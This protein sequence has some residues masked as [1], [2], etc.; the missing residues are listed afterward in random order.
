MTKQ[1]K[2]IGKS[3]W[4]SKTDKSGQRI[5]ICQN[6]EPGGK[7][8]KKNLCNEWV[9]VSAKATAVLCYR[10]VNQHVE[11][12]VE[13]G[14]SIKSDRPKGWKFMRLFVAIDGTVFHKGVEQTDLKGTLPITVITPKV[15]KVKMS[16]QEKQD[17]IVALGKEIKHLKSEL[18]VETRKGKRSELSRN[19]TKA[20]RQLNKLM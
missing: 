7:W 20:S 8:W 10:C 5:M 1:V 13:R 15:E 17:A 4:K 16:L 2:E 9:I 12:P 3:K 19:L 14:S 11:A 18:I 6:S